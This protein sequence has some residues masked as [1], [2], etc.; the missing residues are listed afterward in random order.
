[1]RP[2]GRVPLSQGLVLCA[3]TP[4]ALRTRFMSCLWASR[5]VPVAGA[6]CWGQ[7]GAWVPLGKV[8]AF[9][10]VLSATCWPRLS[11]GVQPRG[12]RRA[13]SRR[14]ARAQ[15]PGQAPA[16]S[17]DS[18]RA[19][20]ARAPCAPGLSPHVPA[21]RLLGRRALV[22]SPGP[23][24]SPLAPG[25]TAD[26][27]RLPGP[28]PRG[29]LHVLGR[30][31]VPT[32]LPSA[33]L[34]RHHAQALP[35]PRSAHRSCTERLRGAELPPPARPRA[36]AS[37]PTDRLPSHT[38]ALRPGPGRG[39]TACF[40]SPWAS[41]PQGP[42]PGARAG[43]SHSI[44]ASCLVRFTRRDVL[45]VHRCRSKCRVHPFLRPSHSSSSLAPGV[46][47]PSRLS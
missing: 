45:E 35:R 26:G 12:P 7:E 2:G 18:C 27:S 42:P 25:S 6:G 4:G 33:F 9:T 8:L 14:G 19:H 1:M 37:S 5:P 10:S 28:G 29:Q 30:C 38:P 44:C 31:L 11:G 39:P 32:P 13:L 34:P 15:P 20:A 43:G 40:L 24:Q 16:A 36:A 46:T 47:S 17:W 3:P 41:V 22:P 23:S 21:V